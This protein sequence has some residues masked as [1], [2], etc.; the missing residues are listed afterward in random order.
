MSIAPSTN[1][2]L[3]ESHKI[4]STPAEEAQ[5]QILG[6]SAT[7]T[8]EPKQNSASVNSV[9]SFVNEL[10]ELKKKQKKARLEPVM[11]HLRPD[12]NEALENLVEQ[13][14]LTKSKDVAQI[15]MKTLGIK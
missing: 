5:P 8:E 14:G 13:T 12:V 1:K 11:S 7:V 3:Q 6:A 15:I 2:R 9:N 10:R 4:K